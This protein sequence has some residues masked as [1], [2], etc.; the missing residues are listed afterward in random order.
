MDEIAIKV[1]HVS[2][3]YRLYDKPTLRFK[4]AFSISKKQ[5]HKDFHA[6]NDISFEVKKGEML[7]IIGKNG[8]GKSTVL[9]IITGVLTPTAG[10]VEINGK[11]SALL[12]LGAGFNPEYNGIQNAYLSGTMM[13]FSEAEMDEKLEGILKFADIG[14]FIHQ[15]VKTYSSG[16]FARLAFAVAISVDPDILIIDEAL[17]VGDV[18]FQA[19]CYKRMEELKNS[20]KTVLFV[21]HDMGSVMK[22]C[23][24]CI[25]IN[26]GQLYAEGPTKEMIDLYK[27][28]LVG[29]APDAS[30]LEG[31]MNGGAPEGQ[32]LEKASHASGGTGS[33]SD[34]DSSCWK[35]YMLINP[36]RE[37]YGDGRAVIE[38]FG[39]FDE[40]GRITNTIYKMTEFTI[41]MKV[42]FNARIQNP[43][44]AFSIKDLKGNEIS[45][46]NTVIEKVETGVAE[47]GETAEISF[48]QKMILQGGQ[49]LLSLGCTG[50]EQD[51]L[52][53]Y[54]RLYDIC[55]IQVISDK[56]TVGFCDM[57]S[58][59]HYRRDNL[60]G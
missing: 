52:V 54:H 46:T 38:S 28:I 44:F 37:N 5:Y 43:I 9:K 11:I 53:V 7:G 4:E 30:V 15:P 36:N 14:D 2:K 49:Q 60:H 16:M 34:T 10:T 51:E 18:F 55:C 26:D 56:T 6:L 47:A 12:E 23:K 29:Q 24:R 33:I 8:A 1:S 41:R 50:Y 45:G 20:G 22:Y 31:H 27:K 19:K 42:R 21:T 40:E 35:D 57:D 59:V 25:I 13:G 3:V 58:R 17:S 32:S 48:T 39:I